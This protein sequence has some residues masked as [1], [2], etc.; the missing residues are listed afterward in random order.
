MNKKLLSKE[1]YVKDSKKIFSFPSHVTTSKQR[2][3]TAFSQNVDSSINAE[4][5]LISLI[6]LI[7][8]SFAIFDTL[9][10]HLMLE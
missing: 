8:F 5:F 4:N 10:H 3:E 9:A 6:I 1:F 2:K 7:F